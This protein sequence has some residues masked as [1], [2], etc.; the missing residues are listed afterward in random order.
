MAEAS[1]FIALSGRWAEPARRNAL[2]LAVVAL[3][4]LGFL[5]QLGG[6]GYDAA[7]ASGALLP[8]IAAAASAL[9]MARQRPRP[10]DAVARGASI[11][12]VL[13]VAGFVVVLLHGA[14]VGFCDP[15]EGL[16]LYVLGPGFGAVLGGVWGALMGLVTARYAGGRS[17]GVQRAVA[18]ALAV[19]GPLAGIA[20]SF[21]R[22]LSS[23]MVFA[24]D[25]FFGVFAGPLYDTV[26]DV[27]DRLLTYRQGT[28]ATLTAVALGASLFERA[29]EVGLR[30]SALERPGTASL[31]VVTAALSI[32]HSAAGPHFGHWSTAS[33]IEAALGGHLLGRRCDVVHARGLPRRE[34]AL[35]TRDCDASVAQVEAYFGARG[36][37]HIRVYLFANE[38]EKG[39]LMGASHTYIAKPWRREVY[40]QH[41][42]YPHPVIAHELAHVIAGSFARG[43]FH[44]AGPLGGLWP[45]PGRIEGFA[46]AAAPDETDELTTLE[47]AATMLDLG[48]LPPLR[49]VF[50]LDFLSLSASKAY[51]VAGAF[52]E[53]LR[54]RYG[55][56]ALRRWYAGAPLHD[57][58]GGRE[59]DAL[60]GDFRAAL[61]ALHVTSRA[62]G[63]AQ[64]R[65]ERP[66]FFAR[67]CPRIVDRTLGDAGARLGTGDVSGAAAAYREALDLEPKSFDARF[68]LAACE[69]QRDNPTRAVEQFLA[70]A[71]S[72]EFLQLQLARA[73]ETAADIELAEGHLEPAQNLYTRALDLSFDE[74]RRR[75]LEVKHAAAAG[76]GRRA[77]VTLLVGAGGQPPAWDAAAP[78]IQAWGD[79]D[80][81]TDV[82]SYLIGRNL[83]NA[84]R[85]REA[86]EYLDH[87]L[88]LAP[89]L[90]SVRR[91]AVRLRVI[92]ACALGDDPAKLGLVDRFTHD[93]ELANAR[94][95][96]L[97]RLVERC[98]AAPGGQPQ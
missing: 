7:L 10:S 96:G 54:G 55:M 85:Y 19:V 8:S 88:T 72:R 49:S 29:T 60:D 77:I 12:V 30:R 67:H 34:V 61:K 39:W 65:F 75:T 45:D 59:L 89:T 23:P 33:S 97:L 35:F 81:T 80:F 22:F 41:A 58:T 53:F 78:L 82:P 31:V 56:P 37:E 52:V 6:P 95:V 14:R 27:V 26:V 15:S 13:A 87:S 3:G 43:P 83:L 57:V 1:V 21:Y 63:T 94:K 98:T 73:L 90:P 66:A 2:V 91:E 70:L 25:P 24:F 36:P 46:V 16:W 69:R 86:A 38:G 9:E 17:R 71:K 68:G 92:A 47:W 44:V 20:V 50:Q 28:L 84:G 40:V 64:A 5:P 51:T 93:D 4:A 18:V 11:G 48:I 62:R 79:R 74:D 32:A 42:P 76:R